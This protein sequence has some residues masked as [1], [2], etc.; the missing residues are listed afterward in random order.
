MDLLPRASLTNSC[1]FAP[2]RVHPSTG[3]VSDSVCHLQFS[4]VHRIRHQKTNTS[5]YNKEADDGRV[6]VHHGPGVACAV[7]SARVMTDIIIIRNARA[8][9][10]DAFN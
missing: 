7:C 9:W 5:C 8:H 4:K 2:Y 3:S 1:G 6:T 10:M